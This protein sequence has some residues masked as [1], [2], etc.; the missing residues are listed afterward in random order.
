MYRSLRLLLVLLSLS[1][2][3]GLNGD[4]RE[5][6]NILFIFA[7]DM[8]YEALGAAELLE[9]ETPNLD[10]LS[11]EGTQ[12][13]RVYNMGGW[14]GAI[15]IA[16]RTC[17]NTGKF[18]WRAQEARLRE[19]S[20]KGQTWSQLLGAGGYTTYMSG[21][22][23]V[24]GLDPH[25]VFDVARHIRP[26][27]PGDTEPGY[28]R[29][30]NREDYAYGWKPWDESQGGFWEGGRHWS[31]VLAADGMAYL[32][33]AQGADNPFF[34]YLAF[35]APHDPRQSPKSFVDR[36]PLE[37]VD[38]PAN[39]LPEYPYKEEIGCGADLRD[40]RLA[41][42]PRTPFSVQV[43]RQEYYAL[44]THMDEQI[45]KIL[46][47]LEATG[48]ADSTYIFFTADH[49]LAVGHHGLLGKQNMYE[50]SMRVPF[51]VK[52]PGVSAGATVETPIYLQDIMPTTLE[53]AG[54]A[55]PDHV[56]Y[57]SLLPLMED[58]DAPHY[59][60]IY[61]AYLPD[62]QRMVVKGDYKLI[63]Y[64]KAGI[65]RLF[66]LK[67]DPQEMHDLANW[68]SYSPVVE[69]LTHLFYEL[70]K[71]MADPLDLSSVTYNTDTHLGSEPFRANW[72]SLRRHPPAPEWFQDAKLGIYFHWGPYSV[73]AFG[74]EWYPHNMYMPKRPEYQHHR[75][76]WGADFEYHDFVEMFKA[77]HFDPVA[78]AELFQKAGARFAGPVA[79]HHDGFAMWRSRVTPWNAYDKG[80]GRDI[81][82]ELYQEVRRRGLKTIATFHHA[83]NLQRYQPGEEPY[84]RMRSHYPWAEGR[85]PTIDHPE[86]NYLYGLMSADR[87]YRDI[88]LGKVKEVIADYQPDILW[89]DSWLDEVPESVRAEM[90]AAYLNA[91]RRWDKEV[92]IVRKQD[93]LPAHFS[94]LDLEKSRV[95]G[96]SERVW[97]TDDTISKGSW[98]Y[99]ED[100]EIKSAQSVIHALAD[101]V[102]KN[103]VVLLN[104]SPRADGI[105][106]D[107]QREV[108]LEIGAW[109]DINGE[110]IYAT[111]PWITYGEGPMRE[112]EGG[113]EAHNEFLKLEYGPADIRFTQAKNR[114]VLYAISLGWEP[115]RTSLSI[116][117]LAAG[118]HGLL[119][120]S[121]EM[122]GHGP[123]A[124]RRDQRGLHL[125]LPGPPPHPAAVV[126]KI[127]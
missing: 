64:P 117:S 39:F 100:M 15:C 90:C 81:M 111:R 108:L 30:Q 51:I 5:R 22:W 89:F 16:S 20:A 74:S 35:N 69:E 11:R 124:F 92:V 119:I 127:Q 99:T 8:T 9:V 57:K 71:E 3:V 73:P 96:A 62:T 12:F 25:V 113:F 79:E 115:G 107:D 83:R 60:A 76:K 56:D 66:N 122:L 27:M 105:I 118:K 42:F 82:G 13:T 45:G 38:V 28:D 72:E 59:R 68:P 4:A 58:P 48:K 31:E 67:E 104:I 120:R 109:L 21:K 34:M 101:T 77:E 29:P 52:G 80:P 7:D 126:F 23:H 18:L 86:R 102:S 94:V 54:V 70:Q 43:H 84:D 33:Q 98:S 75:E 1:G 6:P 97:M 121:V 63:L 10:R 19:M 14:N 61:G 78:W 93:D 37:S 114:E 65:K 50:H 87:W 116:A 46:E 85:A 2:A 49:G 55:V 17:I 95:P 53:L 112:P 26:G 36:Y 24:A 41:P 123:V 88:W 91:A 103:G 110:A 44:I 40:E 32:E 47:A 106:P 125:D